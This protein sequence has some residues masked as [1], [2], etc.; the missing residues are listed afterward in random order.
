MI[1]SMAPCESNTG[2]LQTG[3]ELEPEP[4]VRRRIWPKLQALLEGFWD[5]YLLLLAKTESAA[6]QTCERQPSSKWDFP[7]SQRRTYYR[8]DQR[9]WVCPVSSQS[10][11]TAPR[12]QIQQI[13]F[14]PDHTSPSTRRLRRAECRARVPV[15]FWFE[16]R[17][18]YLAQF[19][20]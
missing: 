17:R 1:L 9:P 11:R 15:R 4:R 18:D 13:R 7:A 10:C 3:R 19:Q 14:L 6:G 5:S 20:E 8:G 12:L 16:D 2:R